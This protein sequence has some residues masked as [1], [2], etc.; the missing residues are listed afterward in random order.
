MLGYLSVC[1]WAWLCQYEEL[2]CSTLLLFEEG[3]KVWDHC[4]PPE[5]QDCPHSVQLDQGPC[6]VSRCPYCLATIVTVAWSRHRP[7]WDKE[8]WG[9]SVRCTQSD[10]KSPFHHRSKQKAPSVTNKSTIVREVLARL[11]QGRP[12]SIFPCHD[13]RFLS[14][15]HCFCLRGQLSTILVICHSLPGSSL[16]PRPSFWVWAFVQSAICFFFLFFCIM[17]INKA[18]FGSWHRKAIPWI[19]EM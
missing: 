10:R 5:Y 13:F 12:L 7:R 6:A 18:T 16:F 14:I 17:W 4:H 2:R 1:W 9:T 19:I 8:P 15:Y 3:N 11:L